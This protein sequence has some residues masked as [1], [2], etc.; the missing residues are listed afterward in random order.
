MENFMTVVAPVAY[1]KDLDSSLA[2]AR[3]KIE[4]NNKEVVNRDVAIGD[5]MIAVLMELQDKK[6]KNGSRTSAKNGAVKA[7]RG[8][9]KTETGASA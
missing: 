6:V 8:K 2:K 7:A 3:M 5:G 9:A 1:P 4:E